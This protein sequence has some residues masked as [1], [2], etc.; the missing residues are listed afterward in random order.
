ML[1]Q[2]PT[3]QT[4][5]SYFDG[6]LSTY[7]VINYYDELDELDRNEKKLLRTQKFIAALREDTHYQNLAKKADAPDRF[8]LY[9]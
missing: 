7:G 5:D 2:L 3:N 1:S 4:G 9:V 8:F 6:D